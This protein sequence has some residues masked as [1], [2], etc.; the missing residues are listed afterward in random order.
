[1]GKAAPD[2]EFTLPGGKR[3]SIA[4]QRGRVLLINF[5]A[6]WCGPCLIE[7]PSLR[8][9]EQK[10]PDSELGVFAFHVEGETEASKQDWRSHGFPKNLVFKF[11][12]RQLEPY[13]VSTIPL[14]VLV[15]K[16]GVFRKSYFGPRDW[17]AAEALKDIEGLGH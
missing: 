14:T 15:D 5:W 4:K 17:T 13:R 7:M 1:M 16:Q 11:D 9:L 10:F 8:A 3:S 6:A 2:I 12:P